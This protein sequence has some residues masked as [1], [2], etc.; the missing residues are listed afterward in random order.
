MEDLGN[1]GENLPVVG[2]ALGANVAPNANPPTP[3][4]PHQEGG[5]ASS[6]TS[7][8]MTEFAS[9]MES[10]KSSMENSMKALV[11]EEVDK[12]L[13]SFSQTP[14]TSSTFCPNTTL[15]V[16]GVRETPR[17]PPHSSAP[18]Y[19]VA[20]PSYDRPHIPMPHINHTGDPPPLES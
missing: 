7:L 10:F 12:K 5:G 6:S 3:Q 4:I 14:S 9:F 11:R 15:D 8:T 13:A 18:S 1:Q 19:N 2:G 20:A 17:P 16:D